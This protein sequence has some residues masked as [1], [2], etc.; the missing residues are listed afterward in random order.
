MAI[1]RWRVGDGAVAKRILSEM[2][3]LMRMVFDG[4]V[5]CG[6]CCLI[7]GREWMMK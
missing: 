7:W 2:V 4:W 6:F 5:M 3:L 1:L